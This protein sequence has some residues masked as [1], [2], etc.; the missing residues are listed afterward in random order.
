ME[1]IMGGGRFVGR[2]DKTCVD[3]AAV[4]IRVGCAPADVE[5]DERGGSARSPTGAPS[6][7]PCSQ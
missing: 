6:I 1:G 7:F 3:G 2:V 4:H 5:G